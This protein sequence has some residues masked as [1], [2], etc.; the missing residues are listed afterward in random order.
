MD[1]PDLH[2]ILVLN[3]NKQWKTLS[4][5]REKSD[6]MSELSWQIANLIK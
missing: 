5:S 3:L 2:R 1:K 6:R 4:L